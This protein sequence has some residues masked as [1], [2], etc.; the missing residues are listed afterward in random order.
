[1]NQQLFTSATF[2]G[3]YHESQ[4]RIQVAVNGVRRIYP[5]TEARQSLFANIEQCL[6]CAGRL[7]DTSHNKSR[8]FA[9]LSLSRISLHQHTKRLLLTEQFLIYYIRGVYEWRETTCRKD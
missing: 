4:M 1:M 7:R 5:L 8:F 6:S 9:E 2:Q 3:C